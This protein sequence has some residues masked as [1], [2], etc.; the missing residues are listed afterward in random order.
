[1]IPSRN[2]SDDQTSEKQPSS[3]AAPSDSENLGLNSSNQVFSN[4]CSNHRSNQKDFSFREKRKVSGLNDNITFADLHSKANTVETLK[5]L[6]KNGKAIFKQKDLVKKN[7]QTV[8]SEQTNLIQ[9]NKVGREIQTEG[10]QIKVVK[11]KEI[12]RASSEIKNRV[13]PNCDEFK[14]KRFRK[15]NPKL[16]VTQ[17]ETGTD[18][19]GEKAKADKPG[20]K[21]LYRNRRKRTGQISRNIQ[22]GNS[23]DASEKE[24][25]TKEMGKIKKEGGSNKNLSKKA[26]RSKKKVEESVSPSSNSRKSRSLY[27]K[28]LKVL[29]AEKKTNLRK[30]GGRNVNEHGRKLQNRSKKMILKFKRELLRNQ[31]KASKS[32]NQ[33]SSSKK[34][35]KSNTQKNSFSANRETMD[36]PKKTTHNAK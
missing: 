4:R 3:I 20:K 13:S 2:K 30:E 19:N 26:K 18:T 8:Q 34:K 11:I 31:R 23:G 22:T 32:R 6:Q 12:N 1:M 5:S 36:N 25:K 35:G 29:N 7:G 24:E 14:S 10:N 9:S 33:V 15:G 21:S 27:T 17:F 28:K 16:T